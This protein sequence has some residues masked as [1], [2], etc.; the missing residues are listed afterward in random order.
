MKNAL[1]RQRHKKYLAGLAVGGTASPLR[2][3]Q[4][5]TMRPTIRDS[6][7]ST[8]EDTTRKLRPSKTYVSHCAV[9]K[10]VEGI[11]TQEVE[12]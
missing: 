4:K 12:K 7:V 6:K 3:A 9:K 8:D 10:N 5:A 11:Y 2:S 1:S